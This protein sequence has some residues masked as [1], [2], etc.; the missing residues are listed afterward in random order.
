MRTKQSNSHQMMR[1]CSQLANAFSSPTKNR[2]KEPQT[3]IFAVHKVLSHSQLYKT[4][5]THV[6]FISDLQTATLTL[7]FRVA[8]LEETRNTTELEVRV[9]DLEETTV[10]QGTSIEGTLVTVEIQSQTNLSLCLYYLTH[11]LY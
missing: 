7:D 5:K 9:T 8:V 2:K 10:E 3:N 1:K 4:C 6:C 11:F